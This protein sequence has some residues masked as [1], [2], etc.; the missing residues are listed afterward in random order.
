MFEFEILFLFVQVEE[1]PKIN[2][3]DGS[4]IKNVLDDAVRDVLIKKLNYTE[5]F[6]LVDGRLGI[7]SIGVGIA[8][9]ALL[10][11]YLYPFPQS[12]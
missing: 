4:A 3:W 1:I 7:C 12:K 9:L 2:K 8:M 10:W 11:D 5:N 6:A